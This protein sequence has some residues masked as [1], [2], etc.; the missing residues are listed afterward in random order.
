MES[1]H[2]EKRYGKS[3]DKAMS[4]AEVICKTIWIILEGNLVIFSPDT[5]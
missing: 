5:V 4:K 3:T 1:Q 2:L